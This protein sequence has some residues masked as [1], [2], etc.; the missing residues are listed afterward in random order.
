MTTTLPVPATQQ[1]GSEFA[2]LLRQI[3]SAGLLDRRRWNYTFRIVL[4]LGFF[5]AT[6]WAFA[7][8]G[9]SWLQVVIAAA[10][11]FAF[12]QVAFLGHDGGHQQVARTKRVNDLLGLVTGNLL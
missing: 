1:R 8:V 5:A 10:M 7:F 2:A 4:T 6:W 9:D 3:R 11:G 12:T